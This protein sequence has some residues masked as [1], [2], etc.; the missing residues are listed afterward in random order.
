MLG[1][2][3]SGESSL[4]P[5]STSTPASP[6]ATAMSRIRLRATRAYVAE[7]TASPQVEPVGR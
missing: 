1:E 6:E 5:L 3:S 2:P 7:V 4:H